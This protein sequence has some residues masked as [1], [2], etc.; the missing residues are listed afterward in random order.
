[1][2]ERVSLPLGGTHP[3]QP[4]A[5]RRETLPQVS[6]DSDNRQQVTLRGKCKNCSDFLRQDED[7]ETQP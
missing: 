3:C 6:G 4:M 5:F 7:F 1:M 2:E